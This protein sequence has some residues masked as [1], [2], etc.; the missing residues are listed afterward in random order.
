MPHASQHEPSFLNPI[1]V[2]A[3]AFSAELIT[4]SGTELR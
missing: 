1:A 4:K 2:E 3:S